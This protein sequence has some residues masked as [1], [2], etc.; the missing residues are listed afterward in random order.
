MTQRPFKHRG[1]GLFPDMPTSMSPEDLGEDTK[2]FLEHPS[3][4]DDDWRAV[5]EEIERDMRFKKKDKD[6]V[7]DL[8]SVV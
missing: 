2:A 8:G 6:E 3:I 1:E 7:L 4:S 5:L